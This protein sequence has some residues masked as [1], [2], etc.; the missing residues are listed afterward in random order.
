MNT[1]HYL[2]SFFF[3]FSYL[4]PRG[5]LSLCR[6][7]GC[8]LIILVQIGTDGAVLV[9]ALVTPDSGLAP[10][11]QEPLRG[12][13]SAPRSF[14]VSSFPRTPPLSTAPRQLDLHSAWLSHL[15]ST[16]KPVRAVL[17]V[18]EVH[19]AFSWVLLSGSFL[20]LPLSACPAHLSPHAVRVVTG[21]LSY[22]CGC[23]PFPVWSLQHP[24][25]V[26]LSLLLSLR[27]GAVAVVLP[28]ADLSFSLV[29]QAWC[30]R[31]ENCCK[32]AFSDGARG[33]VGRGGEASH[34]P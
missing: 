25:R 2:K 29:S 24:L 13:A 31:E 27:L 7:I 23:F 6:Q 17:H 15:R 10:G 12:A 34:T 8:K 3:F 16:D 26:W 18:C 21:A 5:L 28:L 30:A 22:A 9:V 11:H 33:G 32:Q 14:R 19:V 4:S 20:A 1:R